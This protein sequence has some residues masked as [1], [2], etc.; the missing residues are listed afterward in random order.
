MRFGDSSMEEGVFGDQRRRA[1]AGTLSTTAAS[2]EGVDGPAYIR[3]V[4]PLITR[5]PA[6]TEGCETR[7][8]WA[9]SVGP[10]PTEG[11][12]WLCCI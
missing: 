9:R 7:S 5:R 3:G 11:G 10:S 8:T 6:S 2:I 12:T 1:F 4:S